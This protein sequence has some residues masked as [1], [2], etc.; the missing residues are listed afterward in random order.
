MSRVI[1][2][3]QV[4]TPTPTPGYIGY[5]PGFQDA[6]DTN[7]LDRSGR[8]NHAVFG[9]QQTASFAWTT[10]ANRYSVALNAGGSQNAAANLP[11]GSAF[12]WNPALESL[13][14]AF[15]LTC[16][17]TALN[18]PIF[19]NAYAS[20]SVGFKLE[21]QA[22][23]GFLRL[24]R[25]S[26]GAQTVVNTTTEA[27]ADGTEHGVGFAWDAVAQRAYIYVDGVIASA[28]A[29]GSLITATDW[30]PFTTVNLCI[31]GVGHSSVGGTAA[32]TYA[33]A[34]RGIH[35]AKR[36]GALPSNVARLFNRLNSSPHVLISALE[37][38]A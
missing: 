30:F 34:F 11:N 28:F 37:L 24:N 3:G 16:T 22:T 14:A 31:G 12:I 19:G 20:P 18:G 26:T 13:I 27:V 29:G 23:T 35:I 7:L 32:I 38:P 21:V 6:T 17:A 9:A 5:Y 15:K 25:Y 10:L 1:K 2:L 36:T 8:S 33:S 4:K